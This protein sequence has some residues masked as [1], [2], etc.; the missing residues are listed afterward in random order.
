M[1]YGLFMAV[2]EL[3]RNNNTVSVGYTS[4]LIYS[5]WVRERPAEPDSGL[6]GFHLGSILGL[7]FHRPQTSGT[8]GYVLSLGWRAF[9]SAP[10]AKASSM[11]KPEVKVG[12]SHLAPPEATA[13][14][15]TCLTPQG[16]EVPSPKFHL[17]C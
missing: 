11:G 16:R 9:A 14:T 2:V 15:W 3:Y 17:S 4:Q 10:L 5:L 7:G 13:E 8:P 12:G 6:W 1:L